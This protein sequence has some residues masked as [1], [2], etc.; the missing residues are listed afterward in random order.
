[1]PSH[2]KASGHFCR[3]TLNLG[4]DAAGVRSL[5]QLIH[6]NAQHNPK[7]PFCIQAEVK[8]DGAIKDTNE[9]PPYETHTVTMETLKISVDSCAD[10][11]NHGL[12]TAADETMKEV[13][14]VAIIME[15][16]IGLFIYLAA[17]LE[18][19]IPVRFLLSHPHAALVKC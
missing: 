13:G 6:F 17:L 14:P 2:A 10:W 9:K 8:R 3:P 4:R 1:M 5:P 7:Y 18:L 19:G 16:N 15:S 12:S 11:I